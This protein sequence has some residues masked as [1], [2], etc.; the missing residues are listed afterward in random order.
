[1]AIDKETANV[2]VLKWLNEIANLRVHAT[3][4]EVPFVRLKTEQ[5]HLQKQVVS[6]FPLI[7]GI[8]EEKY[9]I[10]FESLETTSFQHELSIYEQASLD[11]EVAA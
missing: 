2:F 4:G 1:M 7:P 6:Y 3:T 11:Q 9:C 10:A 8:S 5:V